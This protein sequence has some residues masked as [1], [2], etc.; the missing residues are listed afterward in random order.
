M[1]SYCVSIGEGTWSRCGRTLECLP[2][3]LVD[4]HQFEP[5]VEHAG[6]LEPQKIGRRSLVLEIETSQKDEGKK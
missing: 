5:P 2:L 4:D 6:L 1:E 3:E